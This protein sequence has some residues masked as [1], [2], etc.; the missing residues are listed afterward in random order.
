MAERLPRYQDFEPE[1]KDPSGSGPGFGSCMS[2]QTCND[3]AIAA[4]LEEFDFR[5][6]ASKQ[7]AEKLAAE[8]DAAFAARMAAQDEQSKKDAAFAAEI[9]ARQHA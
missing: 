4:A 1:T 8:Q 9:A 7:L 6:S 3:A 5:Q 2:G